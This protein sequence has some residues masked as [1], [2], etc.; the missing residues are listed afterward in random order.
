MHPTFEILLFI[1][2]SAA[3]LSSFNMQNQYKFL[4][5]INQYSNDNNIT[6]TFYYRDVPDN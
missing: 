5:P 4:S 2:K 3:I 6:K 1:L